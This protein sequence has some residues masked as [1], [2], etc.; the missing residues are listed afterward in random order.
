[1]RFRLGLSVRRAP[2]SKGPQCGYL[3]TFQSSLKATVKALDNVFS[4]PAVEVPLSEE[5]QQEIGAFLDK[6]RDI[7]DNDSQRI[8]DGLLNVY[9]KYVAKDPDKWTAFLRVLTQLRPAITGQVRH[10]RWWTL[11]IKP[12]LDGIGNKRSTIEGAKELLLSFLV[13]DSEDDRGG[14]KARLSRHFTKEVL[15][16]YLS[17]TRIVDDDERIIAGEDEFVAEQVETVLVTFGQSKPKVNI[18]P[19]R[20]NS[21]WARI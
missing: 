18:M 14:A 11:L 9:E 3:L 6:H 20:Y 4:G 21:C 13:Y 7:D 17:R 12:V 2:P 5:L 15:G 16:I 10:E 19:H 8:Q 1:M